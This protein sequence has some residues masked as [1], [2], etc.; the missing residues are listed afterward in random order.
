MPTPAD[1]HPSSAPQPRRHARALRWFLI[2]LAAL[3]GVLALLIV[4]VTTFDW[5]RAKPW[6]NE[7]VSEATG[8][9]FAIEGD[10]SA[11]WHWPQPLET[12]W[13][14]WV[15]GVTVQA[16]QLSMDNP[17]GFAVVE[18]PAK[19]APD[20]PAL[21]V[22]P[23]PEPRADDGAGETAGDQADKGGKT[24][25]AAQARKASAALPA[26]DPALPASDAAKAE[27]ALALEAGQDA[28]A[29]APPRP[30]QGMGTIE[31][32][33][34]TMR[35]LP[36]LSRKLVLDTVVLTAPDIALARRQDG[37][38]N[39]TF[40]SRHQGE[41]QPGRDTPWDLRVDQLVIRGG[42]LGYV[43]GI[44]NLALRARV[45]TLAP[46]DEQTEDGRYGVHVLLAGNYGKA[47]ISG[48]GVGGPVLTLRDKKVRY[49]LRLVA[50]SGNVQVQT[51]GVLDNPAALS[52]MDLQVQLRAPSMADLFPLTGLVLPNTPPFQVKGR[53]LGSLA[54]DKAVWEY[55]DF[56]GIVGDSDLHG[57]V[58]YTSGKPRPKLQGHMTSKQLRLADLGPVLG[59]PSGKRTQE[60]G[61]DKRPGKVLPDAHFAADRW[62][63]MD[64]D[65]AFAGEKII[66]PEALP[67]DHLSVRAVLDDRQLHLTPLRFGFAQG[68]IDSDVLL[69]G[70]AKPLQVKLKGSVEGL[71]LSALFPKVELMKK[72]FGRLD[73]SLQLAGRGDSIAR[74]LA[75]SDGGARL[76]IRNGT[77]SKEMLDL[78]AL[79]LG[80]VVVAKLFGENE[81]VRLRCAV[82]DWRVKDGMADANRVRLNTEEA[83]VDVTGLVD[84][85]DETM[86]L[87]I[88]P[89]SLE[90]K[91]L[92]L[93]TPLY[94]RGTFAHP[95]VGVEPGP[96]LLRAGA[97]VAA[98][99]IAPAALALVPITV[100]GAEDDASCA[101]LLA[102]QGGK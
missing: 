100:P 87:R 79:N 73:G 75:S 70:R 20:L 30:P 72:S 98:A 50:R 92:S 43:D 65:L 47:A 59:A 91:F 19:A 44:K 67:L 93:R 14:R 42:W 85:G 102:P 53:L 56:N 58:T 46:G 13:R 49:P 52:G 74:M 48:E 22:K 83:I 99:A 6:V 23:L 55:R 78:A 84:L 90:W 2:A 34:A 94:V 1:S 76:Y 77:F 8:R 62:G 18:A 80:S 28:Q 41:E 64:L 3:L 7:K 32:A 36:L 11:R 60:K 68:R 63:A 10:L 54:P 16:Q 71:Q 5:N 81:E 45:D 31:S 38:N 101:Q 86:S 35:L 9:R 17:Q 26:S 4:L 12:G 21:P 96:L 88:R 39:W 15:P 33:S 66:R 25:K 24:D 95:K 27:R 61:T 82:A 51:E 89:K 57:S 40:A 29:D 37:L 69:D 97:A